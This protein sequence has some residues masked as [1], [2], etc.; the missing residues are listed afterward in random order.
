MNENLTSMDEQFLGKVNR[1]IED[2]LDNENF[3]VEELAEKAGLSRSMLHRKLIKIA[4][5]S[6]SDLIM[7]KRLTR[8]RELLEHDVGSASEIAYKVGFNS[9]S[10][11]HRAF[12]KRFKVSPGDIKK[13]VFVNFNQESVNPTMKTEI[14]NKPKFSKIII[15]V[16]LVLLAAI[17]VSGSI[18]FLSRKKIHNEKSIAILPFINLSSSEENQYF[19]DGIVEDLLTRLSKIENLKVISRTSSEMFRNKGDKTVPEIAGILGVK[20]VLEGSVQ[21]ESENVR[22]S[23]QLIDAPNDNH[24]LSEQY[25]RKLS[26]VFKLQGEI[27]SA[28]VDKLSLIL[29]DQQL[30]DIMESQTNNMEA[31]NYYQIGKYHQCRCTKEE[32]LASIDYYNK[33]IQADSNYALAYAGMAEAYR[34]M[35]SD[36][37]V[38]KEKKF[39]D[40]AF[41]LAQKALDIDK[42]IA[43]AHTVLATIYYMIDFDMEGAEE[44]F[45]KAIKINSNNSLTYKE[46]A[47]F[48]S[49]IDRPEEAREYMNK[50]LSIDPFS[51]SI[52][53]NSVIMYRTEGEYKK[54]LEENRLCLEIVKDHPYSIVNNIFINLQLGN[55][56]EALEGF[57]KWG[58]A[59]KA[60]VDSAYRLTGLKGL[61]RLEATTAKLWYDRANFYAFLGEKEKAIE[62]LEIAF[63]RNELTPWMLYQTE[64]RNMKSDPRFKVIKKKLG[65]EKY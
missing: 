33:A 23:I 16:V 11:F 40:T 37:F 18:Y 49:I 65:L 4:G 42:N 3:S 58:V 48:L 53:I 36:G 30:S 64:L 32:S 51:F 45:Q 54:A 21:R 47:K 52:R 26:E 14:S 13:K 22:I 28:I 41:I 59:S 39:R 31:L 46:Y 60:Q 17:I 57:K 1:I 61:L 15:S 9:V 8:A 20:Y 24:V 62:N 5:K 6:A 25:D 38:A 2:N 50:A 27:A 10:Y 55:E 56:K 29:T 44:E 7:E 19:A 63:E 12:K 43:E 35:Y 34:A